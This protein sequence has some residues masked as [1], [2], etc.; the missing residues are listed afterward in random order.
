MY[1]FKINHQQGSYTVTLVT[2]DNTIRAH[3][4]D[5]NGELKEILT[6]K[7]DGSDLF[8]NCRLWASSNIHGEFSLETL[9]RTAA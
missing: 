4:L 8:D 9:E 2:V 3:V 5:N 6:V 7:E 1:Y